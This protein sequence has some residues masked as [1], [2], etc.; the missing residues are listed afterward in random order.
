MTCRYG[1]T[2]QAPDCFA[3]AE[4]RDRMQR[5]RTDRVLSSDRHARGCTQGVLEGCRVLVVKNFPREDG[6]L[7]RRIEDR[8]TRPRR[9][10]TIGFVRRCR[11]GIAIAVGR[12]R[13][14][15]F[16]FSAFCTPGCPRRL[17]G[18]RQG[19]R[20]RNRLG[21]VM[22]RRAVDGKCAAGEVDGNNYDRNR[23]PHF[24]RHAVFPYGYDRS[25]AHIRRRRMNLAQPQCEFSDDGAGA[26]A[27]P[28]DGPA[29]RF[30][31]A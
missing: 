14:S 1:P 5:K 31:L 28:S 13:G 21:R 10:K 4:Q 6:D 3:R 12:Q 22:R 8:L 2:A 7:P 19:G 24:S 17:F 25:L 23:S 16:L 9:R 11:I 26:D 29:D 30:G 20:S 15:G 18:S 27:L